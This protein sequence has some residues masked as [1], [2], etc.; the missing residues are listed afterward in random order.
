MQQAINHTK[1]LHDRDGYGWRQAAGTSV[2]A[3]VD[4]GVKVPDAVPFVKG[5]SGIG[6][7][8]SVSAENNSNQSLE[9]DNSINKENNSSKSLN[10]LLRA[11]SNEHYTKD[12]TIDQS[13]AQ[14]TKASYDQMQSYGKSISQ[15]REEVESYSAALHASQNKGA[16]DR[17]DMTHEAELNVAKTY[18]VSQEAAHK[19]IESNDPRANRVWNSMVQAETEKELAQVRASK[20]L[21]SDNASRDG[22]AFQNEHSGKI[23]NQGQQNLQQQA[24]KEGLDHN[25]MNAR[26]QK[27]EHS[28]GDKQQDMTKNAKEQI[29]AVEHHNTV[30]E[31]GMDKKVQEYEK[32]RIG[33]GK[34]S[35]ALGAL[36]LI[37]TFGTSGGL[38]VGGMNSKQKATEYLKGGEKAEQ[39][40]FIKSLKPKDEK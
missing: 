25:L 40:P 11:A 17:R 18:G 2:K 4:A 10:T 33:Q 28:L 23:N 19:M 39:I 32:D 1:S 31:Q 8:G 36:A 13:L 35:K 6:I 12:D 37:P 34:T 20:N 27:A 16:S 30:I 5:S 22:V 3:Y 21:V 26:I 7:D 15:K 14:S 38:N 29:H 9:K 24:A